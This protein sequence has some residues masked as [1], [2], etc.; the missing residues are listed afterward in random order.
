QVEN[1]ET[2]SSPERERVEDWFYRVEW[3]PAALPPSNG[4]TPPPGSW[5]LLAGP[6]SLWKPLAGRL[7]ALGQYVSAVFY[8]PQDP[9]WEERIAEAVRRDVL[10]SGAPP[11]GV[12]HL[13]SVPESEDPAV[14]VEAL[15]AAPRRDSLAV[16]GAI[17]QIA[18]ER[19]APAPRLWLVTRKAQAVT[20]G[21]GVADVAAAPLWGLGPVIN[22]EYPELRCTNVDI[23]SLEDAGSLAREICAGD[24]ETRIA[25]RSG[26]RFVAR[27]VRLDRPE[28]TAECASHLRIPAGAAFRVDVSAP[29]SIANLR[30]SQVSREPLAADQIE[31]EVEAAG[32]NFRDV[33]KVLGIYPSA[34]GDPFWLGDECAGTVTRVA[35]GVAGFQPGD[36]VLAIAP[37]SMGRYTRLPAGFAAHIPNGLSVQ[38]AAAIPIAFTTAWHAFRHLARLEAGETV[39]IHAAAGGVGLAAVQLAFHLGAKVIATAGSPE[40]RDYLRSLGVEHV[41]DS[42][43]LAFADQIAAVTKGK[44]VDVVLNSLGGA[45]IPRSLSILG[46]YGRFVEIGKRDI[47]QNSKIGLAPFRNNLAF[48]SVDMEKVFR[49]R[50]AF[51]AKLLEEVVGLFREGSLKPLPCR[52]FPMSDAA[53]GFRYLAQARNTGKVVF[54][55]AGTDQSVAETDLVRPDRTY[56]IAGGLGGIGLAVARWLVG[57]GAT[58]LA[59]IGRRAP[60]APAEAILNSEIRPRCRVETVQADLSSAGQVRAAI[61]GLRQKLPPLAGVVHAAGVLQD[62]RLLNMNEERFRAVLGPKVQG[63]WNLH[64]ETLHDQLDFFLLFSSMASVFGSPGQANYAA[65]NAFLDA[66]AHYRRKLGLPASAVNWGPWSEIG[67]AAGMSDARLAEAGMARIPPE[68]GLDAL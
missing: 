65:A 12:V 44:G 41:F 25:F 57:R 67:M 48:Y 3:R 5:L 21:S 63:A 40:K 27:L 49:E 51:A 66:L 22:I 36:K 52:V 7:S 46:A 56:L 68:P 53:S 47:F 54:S 61:S 15:E 39:L 20:A 11:R 24:G 33:M 1:L 35:D 9:S 2:A 30:V 37:R 13:C 26:E 43:S 50:P 34:P 58:H 45:A 62:E 32:L 42:R 10:G 60:G 4:E 64:S 31:V 8:D 6:D 23:E 59:L 29:G 19:R 55:F 17:R 14:S 28:S 18:E 16:I 38:E